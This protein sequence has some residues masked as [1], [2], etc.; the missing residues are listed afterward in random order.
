MDWIRIGARKREKRQDFFRI[1][2]R[3][4]QHMARYRYIADV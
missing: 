4:V 3:I 1:A 2:H